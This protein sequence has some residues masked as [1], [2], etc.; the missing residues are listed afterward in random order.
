MLPFK[1]S[2]KYSITTYKQFLGY[3][4]EITKNYLLHGSINLLLS[5]WEERQIEA[6]ACLWAAARGINSNLVS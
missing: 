5:F 6:G 4:E 2:S 1:E 3:L